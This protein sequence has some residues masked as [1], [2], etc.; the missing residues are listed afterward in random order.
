[1]PHMECNDFQEGEGN[2]A[3]PPPPTPWIVKA[4][5]GLVC[6][7]RAKLWP[8]RRAETLRQRKRGNR[9]ASWRGRGR[10]HPP[11][12]RG[13][14]RRR[15]CEGWVSGSVE[16]EGFHSLRDAGRSRDAE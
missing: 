4:V 11:P 1:M 14:G 6:F 15:T 10:G 16:A 9:V 5:G 2:R 8:I 3:A 13:R 12:P 7:A